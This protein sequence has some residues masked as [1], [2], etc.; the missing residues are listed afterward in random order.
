MLL[1]S[2]LRF[3]N[4]VPYCVSCVGNVCCV[5]GEENEAPALCLP[6]N[7]SEPQDGRDEEE[8]RGRG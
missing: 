3:R 8:E 5:T 4:L 2:E 7:I 1:F 6:L